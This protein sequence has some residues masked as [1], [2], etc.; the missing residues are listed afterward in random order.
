MKNIVSRFC[1]NSA[2]QS[3]RVT[4]SARIQVC[5]AAPPATLA[6]PY[7]VPGAASAASIT[8]AT[9]SSVPTSAI[10][11]TI[12]RPPVISGAMFSSNFPRV[13][14]A[15]ITVAPA[16]ASIRAVAVPMP[17][18]AAPVTMIVRP[19]KS[20]SCCAMPDSSP[21]CRANL[22]RCGKRE[23]ARRGK[24]RSRANSPARIANEQSC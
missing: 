4:R 5:G 7:S 22:A 3:A 2:R 9:P 15:A 23:T 21:F 11:G 10:T 16:S 20:I 13:R 24:D 14:P 6:S 8:C 12:D 17:P 18:P 19:V 1:S